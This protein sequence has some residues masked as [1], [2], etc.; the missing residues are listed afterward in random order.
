MG[1]NRVEGA[2][3]TYLTDKHESLGVRDDL[4]SVQSLEIQ[5]SLNSREIYILNSANLFKVC[6]GSFPVASEG[7]DFRTLED[8]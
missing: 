2:M 7:R 8:L 1:Y 4:A 3:I 6:N 5:I